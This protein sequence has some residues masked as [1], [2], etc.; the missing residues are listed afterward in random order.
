VPYKTPL[1]LLIRGIA[2]GV[3]AFVETAS[4]LRK[5]AD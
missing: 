3:F 5:F 4:L 2:A 1:Y